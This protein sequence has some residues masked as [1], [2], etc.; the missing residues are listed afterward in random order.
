MLRMQKNVLPFDFEVYTGCTKLKS[1][2]DKIG[3]NS[4][5][6]GDISEI[7]AYNR[8]YLGSGYFMVSVKFYY[9]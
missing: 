6:I 1:I 4:G 5:Y 2:E 7:F 8:W 3:Y 9:N